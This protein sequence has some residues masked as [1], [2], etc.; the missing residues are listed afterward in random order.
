MNTFTA[1]IRLALSVFL[2][3]LLAL[4][5]TA[6]Q[7]EFDE[8]LSVI[9]KASATTD[10]ESEGSSASLEAIIAEV[11]TLEN[12]PIQAPNLSRVEWDAFGDR[13]E[14]ALD[15]DHRGLHHAALRL[16]IA[17]GDNF[18]LDED[19]VFDVMR[20][21]RDDDSERAR[22]MAVVALAEMDS[23][24]AFEFLKRSTRFE[25]SAKVKQ[26]ILAV[27]AEHNQDSTPL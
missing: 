27:L 10:A 23:N 4:P 12:V 16:V 22:R 5:A 6:Q 3:V 2:L 21:Y 26:T 14:A 11:K 24:W 7:S 1:L 8:S 17:Y 9:T 18:H 25:K 20:I 15:T 19:A 13:L